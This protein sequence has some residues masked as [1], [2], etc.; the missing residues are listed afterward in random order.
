MTR[1]V[2][3]ELDYQPTAIGALSLRRRRPPGAAEDVY[4]ILLGDEYLMSSRFTEAEEK[5]ADLGLAAASPAREVVIGGLGLGYTARAALA[6][7]TL[8]ELVVVELLAPVIGWHRDGLLPLGEAITGDPRCRLVEA[9]FFAMAASARG[10]DPDRPGRL[11][12]AL[13]VDIDHSPDAHL[14]AGHEDFYT[15]A[16]LADLARWLRPGGVF[17]LWSTAPPDELFMARLRGAFAKAKAHTIAVGDAN[18]NTVYL[19]TRGA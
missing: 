4:E 18:L 14:D 11:W 1:P 17:G 5:L 12:D 3:E 15:A 13:L 10:F 6:D 19:A 16:G 2:F 7:A 8:T 9:D